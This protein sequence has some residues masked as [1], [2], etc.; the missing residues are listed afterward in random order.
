MLTCVQS[1]GSR[2]HQ[3]QPRTGQPVW[4][5]LSLMAIGATTGG[6]VNKKDKNKDISF[7]SP[8]TR[9]FWSSL[10]DWHRVELARH[11]VLQR[12]K[13]IKTAQ[14]RQ[15]AKTV[16]HPPWYLEI[17]HNGSKCCWGS[18]RENS[19]PK[20]TFRVVTSILFGRDYYFL[21]RDG[22]IEAVNNSIN[23]YNFQSF[24]SGWAVDSRLLSLVQK[25]K[26]PLA[27]AN[28][29]HGFTHTSMF[30]P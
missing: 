30:K 6:S 26:L 20:F 13:R 8:N 22:E 3:V 21:F 25:F 29:C 16:K 24:C 11:I 10:A 27:L 17:L 5:V 1:Q 15:P 28:C 4:V 14:K 9:P 7:P 12:R 19:T 18:P 2:R 23:S